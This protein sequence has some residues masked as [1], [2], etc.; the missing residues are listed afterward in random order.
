MNCTM[1]ERYKEID[2]DEA[3][4]LRQLGVPIYITAI[5]TTNVRGIVPWNRNSPCDRTYYKWYWYV[6]VADDDSAS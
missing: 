1:H 2:C 3:E 5:P 6:E 4:V